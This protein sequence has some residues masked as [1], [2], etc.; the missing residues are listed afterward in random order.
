MAKKLDID[1]T[2]DNCNDQERWRIVNKALDD[3]M[4]PINNYKEEYNKYYKNNYFKKIKEYLSKLY[5]YNSDSQ[6]W[7]DIE[8]YNCN[9]NT[10]EPKYKIFQ[11]YKDNL[12]TIN[13]L[14]KECYVII[15]NKKIPL[16]S[17]IETKFKN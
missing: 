14:T 5:T 3:T 9:M 2:F 12:I 8:L 4:C 1:I 16:H 15:E 6:L 17:Y 11:H 7:L 13:Q 10:Y